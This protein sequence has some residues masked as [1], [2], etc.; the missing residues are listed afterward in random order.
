M[1][2]FV[3]RG[4]NWLPIFLVIFI[5]LFGFTPISGDLLRAVNGGFTPT[6]YTSLA[7]STPSEASTGI[8]AGELV[9]VRITNHTGSSKTYHWNASEKGALVS[10]GEETLSSDHSTTLVVPSQ[11]AVKGVLRIGL[12]GT[13]VFVTVPV[14]KS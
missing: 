10:L 7:L 9:R 3:G 1:P 13:S 11:G 6:S 4:R 12:A 5:V 2:T 14:A 8:V